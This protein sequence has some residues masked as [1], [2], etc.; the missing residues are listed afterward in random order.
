ME[1]F[2]KN[3][4]Y[5]YCIKTNVYHKKKEMVK[6][7][8]TQ[9]GNLTCYNQVHTKL[10]QRYRTYYPKCTILKLIR[11]N[12]FHTA[13]KMCFYKLKNTSLHI[14]NELYYYNSKIMD[15]IFINIYKNFP[16]INSIVNILPLSILNDFNDTNKIEI[17]K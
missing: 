14:K 8:K 11:V 9:F 13:E 5:I 16:D 7:G 1:K 15:N 10:L 17:K 6:I 3:D 12:N 2:I 4:G